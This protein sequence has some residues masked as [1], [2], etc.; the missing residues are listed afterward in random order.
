MAAHIS[1]KRSS[2]SC[3]CFWGFV[4]YINSFSSVFPFEYKLDMS[5]VFELK[6]EILSYLP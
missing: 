4:L 5:M 2:L 1:I 3:A 6:A